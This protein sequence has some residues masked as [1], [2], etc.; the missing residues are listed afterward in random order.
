MNIRFT[1]LFV[2][3]AFTTL[4]QK[5]KFQINGASRAYIF[6]NQLNIEDEIDSITTRKANYGHTLLDLGFSLSPNS[7]TEVIGMFRLRNELGGF[8]GGGVSI[9]VRQLTLK[10]V[11][12]N[13]VRYEVGDIDLKMTPYT[14]FNNLE[15]GVVNEGE[16]F[17]LRRDV[18]HYDMFYNDNNTWRMQGAK[19][20]FGINSRKY[21]ESIN[22]KGFI[23]RQRPTD[24]IMTPERIFGG[25]ILSLKQSDKLQI[26]IN[27]ANISDLNGTI[28][29]SVQFKNNVTTIDGEY[30]QDL[31]NNKVLKVKLETG[32]SNTQHINNP[33]ANAPLEQD[34]WFVDANTEIN[35]KNKKMKLQLGYKDIGA[36][37]LSPGAQTRRINFSKFPSVYQQITNDAVGRAI[38]YTDIISGNAENSFKISDE[39][40]PYFSAY[41]N[42]NPYGAATPNRQG[43]YAKFNHSDSNGI[44]DAFI[45]TSYLTESRGTGTAKKKQFLLIEAG[46]DIFLNKLFSFDKKIKID[47]GIRYEKTLR[48]GENYEKIDLNSTLIDF[49]A[50]FEISQNFDFLLGAK[51][52]I[53]EGNSF[54]NLRDQFNQIDN[55]GIVNYNF[56]ENT[57]ATGL[58]YSFS[59]R[60]SLSAHYQVFNLRNKDENSVNYGTT[61]MTILYSLTF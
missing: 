40:L 16:V 3:L 56:S 20:D 32:I 48:N 49:G 13:A 17:S 2:I 1:I 5:K 31:K 38:N 8:W 50:S 52:W 55:F 47:A 12:A 45:K 26:N 11:A 37:F 27:S 21:F 24:G 41:N 36:D 59:P 14:L 29:D 9:D 25:G 39:L 34:D 51:L 23:T 44:K 42:S 7:K 61:Q 10:G 54:V 19:L 35:F 53:V 33:D 4:G 15:E 58:K 18:V 30:S 6:S 22:I 43:I 57:Y 46:V 28:Q 60:S